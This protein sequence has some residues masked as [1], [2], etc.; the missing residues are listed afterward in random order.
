VI[1]RDDLTSLR[2]EAAVARV[3]RYQRMHQM[4]DFDAAARALAGAGPD[5]PIDTVLETL[6]AREPLPVDDAQQ[7]AATRAAAAREALAATA[8]GT[9]AQ[10]QMG[11]A[12]IERN[13][14]AGGRVEIDLAPRVPAEG[15]ER[16]HP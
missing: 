8:P 12:A 9:L 7:L 10:V 16:S 14:V 2:H 13:D 4:A 3:Q 5:D 11:A 1:T 6:A 15:N